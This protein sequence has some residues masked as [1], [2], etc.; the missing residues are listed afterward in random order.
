M[1][2]LGIHVYSHDAACHGCM[3]NREGLENFLQTGRKIQVHQNEPSVEP[4]RSLNDQVSDEREVIS[5][6]RK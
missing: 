5:F 4:Y 6:G 3:H 2:A 1:S